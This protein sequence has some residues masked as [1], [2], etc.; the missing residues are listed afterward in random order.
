M[1]RDASGAWSV[2]GFLIATALATT[3]S[4]SA[5]AQSGVTKTVSRSTASAVQ[6]Y[7]TPERMAAA[8]PMG[9][10]AAGAPTRPA[11]APLATGAPGV[12]GG[13]LPGVARGGAIQPFQAPKS[14]L[15]AIPLDGS[16]PGPNE[17]FEYF[18]NYTKYPISTIGKL[19]FHDPV[20]GGNFYC[21]ASVTTG[22]LSINNIIWTAGHCIANGG[23]SY[24]YTNWSFCPSDDNGNPMP[25]IGCWSGTGATVPT[26][27]FANGALT[28]DFGIID[29][30]HS[31]TVINADVATVTGGL[32]FAWNWPRD[33]HWIHI[34][35]PQDPAP[36]TGLKLIET[37][38]EHRYDDTPDALGPPTNSWGSTQGHGS[39][40]SAVIL[41]FSY[42]SAF[43]NS[44]VSYYYVSQFGVEIQGPYYDTFACTLWKN[45]TGYTGTC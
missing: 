42:T 18:P 23:Q 32:G 24:F 39:S 12:G 40:G 14:A 30:A 10:V 45:A 1:D 15:T 29:L 19:F 41:F 44:Q 17:T 7:W 9:K 6:S 16:Y 34:G 26:V 28:R 3:I 13:S 31:G 43:I 5:A 11:A 22:S 36:W 8:K 35:Y 27:W 38:A 33:Q 21:T 20:G 2:A 25:A 4:G 37:A